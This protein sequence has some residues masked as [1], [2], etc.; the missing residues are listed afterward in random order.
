MDS[1]LLQNDQTVSGEYPP[2]CCIGTE[3]KRPEL[4]ADLSATL[5]V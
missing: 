3:Y 5:S 2:S 4:E 1:C